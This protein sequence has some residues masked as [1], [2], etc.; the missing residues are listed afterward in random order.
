M[1]KLTSQNSPQQLRHYLSSRQ[2]LTP[3]EFFR[4]DQH[5]FIDIQRC[6]HPMLPRID[7]MMF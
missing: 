7:A 6:S 5:V 2:I 4:R 1:R 3:R